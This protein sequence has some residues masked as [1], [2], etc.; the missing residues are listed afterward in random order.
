MS[1]FQQIDGNFQQT[2]EEEGSSRLLF[3]N[4][5]LRLKLV[6]GGIAF[7]SHLED[8]RK[9]FGVTIDEIM[10]EHEDTRKARNTKAR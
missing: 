6:N 9:I 10:K 8:L 1:L 4:G 3:L 2:S 5:L 7:I